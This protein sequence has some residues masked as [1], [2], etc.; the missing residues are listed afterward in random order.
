M[1]C[2]ASI[3]GDCNGKQSREHYM[4]G[5]LWKARTV[6]VKG[7]SWLNG[8]EKEIGVR[9]LQSRILCER[10]NHELS[11]LDAEAKKVF[12]TI[13][14]ITQALESNARLKPRNAYCRPTTWS[15]D[16]SRFERWA[17]K[18]LVGLICAEQ[19]RSNWYDADSRANEPP[20]W[21]VHAIFGT[22]FRPPSGLYLATEYQGD[23][24]SGLGIGP[25]CHP[26]SNGIIGG[27]V[28]FG[29]FRFVIWLTH[30]PIETYS[31]PLPGG[32]ISNLP[33]SKLTYRMELMKFQ[34]R[35]VVNQKLTFLWDSAPQTTSSPAAAK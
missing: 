16:G 26:N 32:V 22:Q 9:S 6:R 2:W 23:L 12:Q 4:S 27:N 25:L 19:S 35:N 21:I 3:L 31:V 8:Q 14:T 7:F 5:G 28:S 24:V 17:A 15:V 34:I 29:G 20:A 30:E 10:H 1:N 13:E 11:A 18:F 33:A